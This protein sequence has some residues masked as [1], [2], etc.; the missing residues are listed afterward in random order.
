MRST[1]PRRRNPIENRNPVGSKGGGNLE[2]R[3]TDAGWIARSVGKNGSV[4]R[5]MF[6]M[7]GGWLANE[8]T[9]PGGDK[10]VIARFAREQTPPNSQIRGRPSFSK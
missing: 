3:S 4:R 5:G 2:E 8:G 1:F 6:V 9:L 10:R 7:R